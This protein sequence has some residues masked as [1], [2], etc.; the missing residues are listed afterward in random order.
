MAEAP[1]QPL[2]DDLAKL[3]GQQDL[4]SLTGVYLLRPNNGNVRLFLTVDFTEW[5]EFDPDDIKGESEQYG[6]DSHPLGRKTVWVEWNTQVFHTRAKTARLYVQGQIANR[7]RLQ[8]FD[9]DI[10]DL[11]STVLDADAESGY[12]TTSSPC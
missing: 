12:S 7:L 6:L 9:G 1:T 4:Q 8:D 3:A 2:A 5:L 10:S 11:V